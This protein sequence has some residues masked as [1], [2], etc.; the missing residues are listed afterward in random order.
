VITGERLLF[1]SG[2]TITRSQE[3]GTIRHYK[4]EA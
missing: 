2:G 3:I 4:I 1:S